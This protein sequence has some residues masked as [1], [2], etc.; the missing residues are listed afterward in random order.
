[1]NYTKKQISPVAPGRW[2]MNALGAIGGGYSGYVKARDAA[3][4]A[5]EKMT[6]ANSA[7]SIGGGAL[8]G[9]I[10]PMTGISSGITTGIG[11]ATANKAEKDALAQEGSIDADTGTSTTPTPPVNIQPQ[12]SSVD[13]NAVFPSSNS[14]RVGQVFDPTQDTYGSMFAI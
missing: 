13:P 6:F 12:N 3:E 8:M 5:G 4:E 9:G 2:V 1:M 7:A 10:S 14:A 11:E